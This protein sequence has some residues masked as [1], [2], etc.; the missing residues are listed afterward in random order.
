ML[1][2]SKLFSFF[3]LVD[4]ERKKNYKKIVFI[5]R[6]MG[7]KHLFCI[8]LTHSRNAERRNGKKYNKNL[9]G[10]FSFAF[11]IASSILVSL[12]WMQKSRNHCVRVRHIT[13]RLTKDYRKAI[14]VAR[15]EQRS[16]TW[17]AH[18]TKESDFAWAQNQRWKEQSHFEMKSSRG[19]RE[20]N[21][22]HMLFF[23]K[24]FIKYIYN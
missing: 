19:W 11:F 8:Q 6:K 15:T 20:G 10:H 21:Y 18:R 7:R 12:Q 24:C 22:E 5:K 14:N 23:K 13:H 17:C 9:V 16:S 2:C 3:S 1:I 4:T